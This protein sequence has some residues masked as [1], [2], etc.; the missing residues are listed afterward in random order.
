[1]AVHWVDLD[2]FP[3]L[4]PFEFKLRRVVLLYLGT[5]INLFEPR[6]LRHS[7]HLVRFE[8]FKAPLLAERQGHREQNL[9]K[10]FVF[11]NVY[12]WKKRNRNRKKVKKKTRQNKGQQGGRGEGRKGEREIKGKGKGIRATLRWM[13][14]KNKVL[15]YKVHT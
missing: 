6:F 3:L 5:A 10:G 4:V 14:S 11:K 1:M 2:W 9:N 13:Q 7:P 8:S 15:F 12:S